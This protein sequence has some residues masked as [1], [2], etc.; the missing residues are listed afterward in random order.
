MVK[1]GFKG[2]HRAILHDFRRGHDAKLNLLAAARK[3]S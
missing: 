2:L 1:L 3:G